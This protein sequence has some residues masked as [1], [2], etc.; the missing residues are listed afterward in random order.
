MCDK[1]SHTVGYFNRSRLQTRSSDASVS[2]IIWYLLG[3]AWITQ[4]YLGSS[5]STCAFVADRFDRSPVLWRQL[6]QAASAWIM[7]FSKLIQKWRHVLAR[8]L[9]HIASWC[10]MMLDTTPKTVQTSECVTPALRCFVLSIY[11]QAIL[12]NNTAIVIP[13]PSTATH[14]IWTPS[15][16]LPF[17]RIWGKTIPDFQTNTLLLGNPS[18]SWCLKR[19]NFKSQLAQNNASQFT[20]LSIIQYHGLAQHQLLRLTLVYGLGTNPSSSSR[21]LMSCEKWR[22]GRY[23][24][25]VGPSD[26]LGLG[27]WIWSS[28]GG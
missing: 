2:I 22:C 1:T 25:W 4:K 12:L 13:H 27:W 17:T 23:W 10:F 6:H 24:V 8:R 9:Y 21:W 5:K 18:P 26:G 20:I 15:S 16:I 11:R 28:S 14:W 7:L 3:S 19:P